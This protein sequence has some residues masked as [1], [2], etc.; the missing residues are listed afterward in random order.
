MKSFIEVLDNRDIAIFV[1]LNVFF[2]WGF[3]GKKEIRKSL[4][5]VLKLFFQKAIL[6]PFLLM[7]GYIGL[8]V[9]VFYKYDFWDISRLTDVIFWL[10]GTAFV[11]FTN[12]S[13]TNETGYFK[14]IILSNLKTG[15]L[16]EFVANLYV[17]NLWIEFILVP[18]LFVL[19]AMLG[20]AATNKKYKE[21][22]KLLSKIIGI[23][24]VGI[25]LYFVY[26]AFIDLEGFF[27]IANLFEFLLPLV[28]SLAV[29]P[30]F[31]CF[32]LYIV[33]EKIFRWI[34][35]MIKNPSLARYARRK[36]MCALNINLKL[37]NRWITRTVFLNFESKDD[38][39]QAIQKI[40][41]DYE[42]AT[43]YN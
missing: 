10:L 32:A 25:I 39:K 34:R 22:E 16:L 31:Y 14:K 42:N 37:L 20:I 24:A 43:F 38:I 6:I 29:L 40:K 36:I 4:L 26:K 18:V 19:G 2:I 8:M 30:F 17:F 11:N 33:Y 21:V 23:Y 3:T 9:W 41:K 27:S 13:H 1:W 7:M 15:V 5:T 35:H 12:I 28:F